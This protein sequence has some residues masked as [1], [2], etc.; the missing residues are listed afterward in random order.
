MDILRPDSDSNPDLHGQRYSISVGDRG[1][2]MSNPRV[3]VPLILC[4]IALMLM[5]IT[6]AAYFVASE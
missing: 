3:Y 1:S 6:L 2:V 5:V 4:I